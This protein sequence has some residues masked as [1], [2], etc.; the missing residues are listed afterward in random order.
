[1]EDAPRL[2]HDTK[3]VPGTPEIVRTI[4]E[5]IDACGMFLG[6]VSLGASFQSADGRKKKFPN[7]NVAIEL[8]YAG[9]SV[10]WERVVLVMNTAYGP[11][12]KQVFD[13]KHRRNPI[14]YKLQPNAKPIKRKSEQASL[15]SALEFAIRAH[16]KSEHASVADTIAVL[17]KSSLEIMVTFGQHP[18]F[19]EPT[20]A[21]PVVSQVLLH[22]I[23]RLLELR[24]LRRDVDFNPSTSTV[25]Y[26]YHWTYLGVRAM[27]HLRIRQETPSISST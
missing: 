21:D 27:H 11:A 12:E 6:D 18:C 14:T 5:K 7:P 22:A 15:S 17:D 25:R 13:I 3:G 8:G 23:R 1:M 9:R 26:A 19:S 20:S 2:D 16:M 4:F 10:G 24:L